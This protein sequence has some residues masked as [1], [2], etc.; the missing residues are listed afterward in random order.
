VLYAPPWGIILLPNKLPGI[1]VKD[2]IAQN[3]EFLVCAFG[4]LALAIERMRTRRFVLAVALLALAALFLADIYYVATARTALVVTPLLLAVFGLREFGWKGMA[5]ACLAGAVLFAGL[6]FTSPFLRM[7]VLG[8]IQE[9]S[10]YR[11]DNAVSSAGL[12][13]E[14]WKK[15]LGFIG[16]AP[17]LGHGTGSMRDLFSRSTL[18]ESGA[19]GVKSDNPH[20]QYLAVAVQ[21]GL[22]GTALLIAMWIAHLALFRGVGLV[23]WLGLVIVVQNAVSSLFNSHLFDFFH[24]WLYVFGVGVLGGMALRR[25]ATAPPASGHAP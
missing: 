12:R 17:L 21:L 13:L 11:D 15:S 16:E 4:L 20:N 1:P 18:G 6:W 14:F 7:R 22:V 2:Y 10:Q 3:A 9:I 23:A 5:I 19:S 24:G 25:R 8:G